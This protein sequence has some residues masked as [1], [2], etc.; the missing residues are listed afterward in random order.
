MSYSSM[1]LWKSNKEGYRERYYRNGKSFQTTETIFGKT[2]HE[3][4]EDADKLREKAIT[5]MI[6]DL[7][8]KGFLDYFDPARLYFHDD[9]FSHRSKEGKVPWDPVKV[10]KHEQLPFYSMLV[11]EKFGKVS[12][13]CHLI[14]HETQFKTKTVTFDGH[15]LKSTSR[16]LEVIGKPK[17][18]RRVI[19]QWERD[20]MKREVL[21][22]AR[23]IHKD[24]EIYRNKNKI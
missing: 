2:A 15:V 3:A 9:K 24:F 23:E 13:V 8:V 22:I 16:E 7:K 11:K 17:R 1:T 6:D 21:K 5:V 12:N 4:L 20:R 14:W 19:W 10:R 18:F